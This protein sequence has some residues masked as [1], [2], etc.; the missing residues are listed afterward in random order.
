MEEAPALLQRFS[1]ID[2]RN[3]MCYEDC[4][5][6]RHL[7]LLEPHLRVEDTESY[8]WTLLILKLPDKAREAWAIANEDLVVEAINSGSDFGHLATDLVFDTSPTGR[9][10]PGFERAH[11][12]SGSSDLL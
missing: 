11:L 10:I 7:A 12:R 5:I 1:S 8:A 9:L 3:L 6:A 2:V 4:V